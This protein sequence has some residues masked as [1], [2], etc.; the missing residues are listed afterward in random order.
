M[1]AEATLLERFRRDGD[2][3]S[4]EEFVRATRPR[5]LAVARRIGSP[6]DAEDSVQAAYHALLRR[7]D[8][9]PGVNP[10][11][12]LVT[13]TVRIAYRRKATT[14]RQEDL[15]RQL[16]RERLDDRT[17]DGAI[18]R[19]EDG[20]L[21]AAVHRLPARYRDAVVLHHLEGLPLA[22]V[23]R[24][25]EVP[26]A[27]AKTRVQR[28]RALLRWRLAPAFAVGILFI[29]WLV[30]DAARAAA[31]RPDLLIGGV[32]KT[33]IAVAALVVV[34]FGLGTAVGVNVSRPAA[35]GPPNESTVADAGP[36]AP[37]APAPAPGR[38]VAA[39][40]AQVRTEHPRRPETTPAFTLDDVR[41]VVSEE[42][43][44]REKGDAAP[45]SHAPADAGLNADPALRETVRQSVLDIRRDLIQYELGFDV[46]ALRSG[47]PLT[48]PDPARLE[49]FPDDRVWPTSQLGWV[50][51]DPAAY[52]ILAAD[53]RGFDGT[54]GNAGWVFTAPLDR[55]IA[56]DSYATLI[57]E[58]GVAASGKVSLQSYGTIRC[59]GNFAGALYLDSYATVIVDGD[60]TGSVTATSYATMH[61][62]G[63]FTG[64]FDS[65][66]YAN[67]R[68]MGGF[69]PARVTLRAA[70]NFY[71]GGYTAESVLD[72][73][74]FDGR[75]GQA[76]NP[77]GRVNV[78]L[79]RGDSSPGT[80]QRPPSME[81]T[82][83]PP[84]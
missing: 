35:Q 79:E 16:T 17:A 21:R 3:A 42:L 84:Q 15:A 71:L 55:A 39:A 70:T 31:S 25:L 38:D 24:L 37:S 28:G 9:P 75:A 7:A 26:E 49:K 1:T 43:A 11:A 82:V 36:R 65:N 66:S 53:A 20:L 68:V 52:E 74:T 50:Q 80:Y 33:K 14:R 48:R 81:V 2:T 77:K 57:F 19:E 23:A 78:V 13:A 4:M 58:K 60:F 12:W 8:L 73:I 59:K 41:R 6:Q 46:G 40:E 76:G 83:L 67:L 51:R 62:G 18:R 69:Q 64:S 5:L 56:T 45:Q 63:R 27:T 44:R 22:D 32:M 47:L 34:A 10:T 29:P 72:S 54:R 61:V 30:S